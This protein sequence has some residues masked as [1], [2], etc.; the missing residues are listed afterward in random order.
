MMTVWSLHNAF[1]LEYPPEKAR[2]N[3]PVGDANASE[4]G[5]WSDVS[6]SLA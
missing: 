1:H 5:D 2:P 3:L 6:K 4:G